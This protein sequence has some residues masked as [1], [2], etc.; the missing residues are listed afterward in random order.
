MDEVINIRSFTLPHR[1]DPKFVRRFMSIKS[2]NFRLI[3]YVFLDFVYFRF[4]V[5]RSLGAGPKR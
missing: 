1:Y 3:K 5:K 4:R 2:I